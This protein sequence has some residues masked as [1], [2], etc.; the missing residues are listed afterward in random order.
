MRR[1][2]AE[3]V[4]RLRGFS[5]RVMQNMAVARELPTALQRKRYGKWSFDE[6]STP[7]RA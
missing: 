6:A 1:I 5:L 2:F 4:A 3:D 7:Y